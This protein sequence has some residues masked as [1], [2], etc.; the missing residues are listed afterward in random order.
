M[1]IIEICVKTTTEGS[2][3]VADILMELTNEGV[4]IYDKND[5]NNPTWDYVEE[6]VNLAFE[7]EVLVKGYVLKDEAEKV[8]SELKIKF[9][10]FKDCGINFGS[11]DI[12][13]TETDNDK[14]RD[15]WKKYFQPIKI[16]DVV[17]CPQWIDYKI[18]GVEKVIKIDP[19]LAFGTGEHET[20]SM[21]IALMQKESLIGKNVAD[22]G[23]GS[24]ILALAAKKLGAT[25]VVLT[26]LDSQAIDA[27]KNNF[28]LNGLTADIFQADLL[29]TD[30]G[31][32]DV[33]MAN[34]TADILER[35]AVSLKT[36]LKADGKIIISGILDDRLP[37][38]LEVYTCIGF[39]T[40]EITEKGEWRAVAMKAIW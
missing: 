15:V 4:S 2:E 25:E 38:V 31:P 5:L 21:V 27:A 22:V 14:W 23:C 40:T 16:G 13:L 37:R 1:K 6:G 35:L 32:F 18:E 12:L 9:E 17:I 28:S 3:I 11:L 36:K 26:D 24:G 19:G 39:E 7:E 8:I 30:K 20:T 10:S 29:D 34:L 33:I